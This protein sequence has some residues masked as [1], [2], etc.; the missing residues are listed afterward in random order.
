LGRKALET[1]SASTSGE[2][3][4]V[5]RKTGSSLIGDMT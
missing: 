1:A 2:I 3:E 5:G 4:A